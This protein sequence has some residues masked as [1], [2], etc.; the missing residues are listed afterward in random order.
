MPRSP[1]TA[2]SYGLGPQGRVLVLLAASLVGLE[3]YL[4]FGFAATSDEA[5]LTRFFATLGAQFAVYAAALILLARRRGSQPGAARPATI[6]WTA[7]IACRLIALGAGLDHG[8]PWRG[9]QRELAI[10][11]DAL[12]QPSGY[13]PFLLYDN[14][15][16]R[17]RVDGS[18]LAHGVVPY[19]IAPL[20]VDETRPTPILPESDAAALASYRAEI[21][22]SER[23]TDVFAR[24]S[25][26]EVRTVYG[27]V[28]LAL[29]AA[30]ERLAPGGVLAWKLVAVAADLLVCW[31]V[32]RL[33]RSLGHG[34][35]W[36]LLA[37]SWNPLV[38]KELAASAHVDAVLVALQTG[39]VLLALRRS[40]WAAVALGLAAAIKP[41]AL[42]VLPVLIRRTPTV[43]TW[44][45]LAATLTVVW[46]PFAT[47]VPDFLRAQAHFAGSWQF[48]AGAWELARSAASALGS[49][50]PVRAANAVYGLT[51][52]VLALG[53]GLALRGEAAAERLVACCGMLYAALALLGPVVNPWYALWALPFSA[54]LRSWPWLACSGL[55]AVSYTHYL[56]GVTPLPA[57]LVQHLGVAA[58][59][60]AWLLT[61]RRRPLAGEIRR[62]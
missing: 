2:R 33:A 11:T 31:L 51:V 47:A 45:L 16:W 8:D 62:G 34:A 37:W 36:P 27:P 56:D 26:P 52:L 55:L 23:M 53:T 50:D 49:F 43:R 25:Y 40:P 30:T 12:A 7:A 61:S 32:V 21:L 19:R 59:C 58:I 14:D 22:E 29:F 10:G 20:E 24:T 15:V 39:A 5:A 46:A 4:V 35:C 54:A 60:L 44:L 48:N 41:T 17:Y 28:A 3:L 1:D 38:L 9:L 13:E 18:L 42:L 57:L 6:I